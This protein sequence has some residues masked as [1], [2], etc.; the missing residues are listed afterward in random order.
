MLIT[1][2]TDSNARSDLPLN[3]SDYIRI[4][5][6]VAQKIAYR[7]NCYWG[8][9]ICVYIC[10][11]IIMNTWAY[12]PIATQMRAIHH[13][14]GESNQRLT[15]QIC[16]VHYHR[17]HAITH[18]R[19]QLK[20]GSNSSFRVVARTRRLFSDLPSTLND[21]SYN[22]TPLCTWSFHTKCNYARVGFSIHISGNFGLSTSNDTPMR[23][24]VNLAVDS[25]ALLSCWCI[26]SALWHRFRKR[27]NLRRMPSLSRRSP[28]TFWDRSC[29]KIH[30]CRKKD[31][32]YKY[33]VRSFIYFCISASAK[34]A[35]HAH[36]RALL[37]LVV[38]FLRPLP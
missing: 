31:K 30:F 24:V 5:F 14:I 18:F 6:G 26:F 9:E 8:E 38:H 13:A 28:Y 23:S 16:C 33:S 35:T 2:K 11:Y 36:F 3:V 25:S 12:V 29:Y 32:I 22:S 1:P 10:I 27:E 7:H 4:G 20:F 37:Q 17:L 34:R 19:W 15:E 21:I